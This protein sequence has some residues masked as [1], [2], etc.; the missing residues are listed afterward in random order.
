M[1]GKASAETRNGIGMFSQIELNPSSL[2]RA[3]TRHRDYS[4]IT[5]P[6]RRTVAEKAK[7]MIVRNDS[8]SELIRICLSIHDHSSVEKISVHLVRDSIITPWQGSGRTAL[9]MGCILDDAM[10]PENRTEMLHWDLQSLNLTQ[11]QFFSSLPF[12]RE[13]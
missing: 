3:E 2:S 13:I 5:H 9:E 10:S 4:L 6:H 1:R 11:N 12:Y 7:I 8:Y